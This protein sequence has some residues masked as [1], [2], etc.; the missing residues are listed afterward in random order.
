MSTF[1][2]VNIRTNQAW[3]WNYENKNSAF[4]PLESPSYMMHRLN[5]YTAMFWDFQNVLL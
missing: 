4:L 5:L 2:F 3:F 1:V